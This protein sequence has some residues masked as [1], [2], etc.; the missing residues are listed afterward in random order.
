[1]GVF[2]NVEKGLKRLT[3]AANQKIRNSEF[4]YTKATLNLAI[5][6]IQQQSIFKIPF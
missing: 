3:S 4:D 6:T 5:L 2:I 1:M